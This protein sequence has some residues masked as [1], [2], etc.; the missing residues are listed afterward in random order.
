MKHQL[1]TSGGTWPTNNRELVAKY[2]HTITRFIKSI[3]FYK[4]Q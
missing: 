4:L 3:D 1:K 2:S